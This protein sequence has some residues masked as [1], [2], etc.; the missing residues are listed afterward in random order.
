MNYK[1]HILLIVILCLIVA[2]ALSAC[3]G[4]DRSSAGKGEAKGKEKITIC[5]KTDDAAKPYVELSIP[6]NAAKGHSK[7][8]GD[9]IPAPGDG[10]P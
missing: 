9:I 1:P 7:H 5:H 10:C 2:L 6:E 8:E 3:G 4:G